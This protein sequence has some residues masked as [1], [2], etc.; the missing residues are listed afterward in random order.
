[1]PSGLLQ[2]HGRQACQAHTPCRLWAFRT[3]LPSR[4]LCP[5]PSFTT[6]YTNTP[7][8]QASHLDLMHILFNM[9]SLWE[10]ARQ[11]EPPGQPGSSAAYLRT[12]ALLALGSA[13]VGGPGAGMGVGVRV[14]EGGVEGL[15][16]QSD[17]VGM[18]AGRGCAEERG[19]GGGMPTALRRRA[20]G[21]HAAA[22]AHRRRLLPVVVL[23]ASPRSGL[24]PP[25][26][27]AAPQPQ[28]NCLPSTPP[29]LLVGCTHPHA[30]SAPLPPLS[31]RSRP[32]PPAPPT[33]TPQAA[34][35]GPRP[36]ARAHAGAAHAPR[37]P[38]PHHHDRLLVRGVWVDDAH[39]VEARRWVRVGARARARA[40][41]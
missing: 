33:H 30:P 1:M 5:P 27:A 19:G 24:Q 15:G 21:R 39:R 20:H 18:G 2:Q 8:R 3:A 13:A 40:H 16:W 9:T 11:A 10:L 34:P 12:S 32:P 6:P 26:S 23:G 25:W 37:L 22:R 36:A 35:G 41:A 29:S 31:R 7:A 14:V 28:P 4:R 17:W 38:A